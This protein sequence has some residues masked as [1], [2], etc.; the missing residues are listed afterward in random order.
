MVDALKSLAGRAIT[1]TD[2]K[3]YDRIIISEAMAK[4]LDRLKF[5]SFEIREH[6]HGRGEERRLYTDHFPVAARFEILSR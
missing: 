1:H 4:G 2:G 6:R 3:A 5:E